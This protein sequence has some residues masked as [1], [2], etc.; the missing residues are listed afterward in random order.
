MISV[1]G[2]A[3]STQNIE[4]TFVLIN[5]DRKAD[6]A[7]FPSS[8]WS[9]GLTPSGAC[10]S[11]VLSGVVALVLDRDGTVTSTG[12]DIVIRF[13]TMASPLV[14]NEFLA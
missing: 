3:P 8:R 13:G 2:L 4:C 9:A 5:T 1:H 11:V 6:F 10:Q 12:G 14:A 7:G